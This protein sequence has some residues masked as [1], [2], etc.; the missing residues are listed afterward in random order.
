[1]TIV[2]S[3]ETD[4]QRIIA[5]IIA[6]VSSYIEEEERSK[7][8]RVERQSPSIAL[9]LWSISGREEMMRMRALW[10]RRIV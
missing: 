10:Q 3:V 6:G 7:A 5:A 1:M 9:N 2:Q 8:A 4:R